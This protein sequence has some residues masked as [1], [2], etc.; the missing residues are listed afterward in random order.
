MNTDTILSS[1]SSRPIETPR[2]FARDQYNRFVSLAESTGNDSLLESIRSDYRKFELG[3]FRLVVMGEIKKGKSS[4][5]NGLLG[6]PS[7]LPTASD[8]ATSTVF[9]IVY[10]ARKSI[11]V[12]FKDDIDTGQKKDPIEIT[13]ETLADY[14]TEAGNPSNGKGVDFIAMQI[15]HPLLK[16]GLVIVDTPGV[17]GLY[18][19]HRD[20]TFRYAPNADAIVFVLDSVESV[21]SRDE[22]LFLKDLMRTA[23]SKVFFV[24][25]KIDAT[26]EETW[27]SWRSRNQSILADEIG[28]P[29]EKQ[30]YFPVSSKTKLIADRRH[31]GKYLEK[32]GYLAVFHYLN[33]ILIPAKDKIIAA[34][35]SRSILRS[36][37]EVKRSLVQ[38]ESVFKQNTAGELKTIQEAIFSKKWDLSKWA[39]TSYRS[40]VQVF[41]ESLN[42][43]KRKSV[44]EMRDALDPQGPLVSEL[45]DRYAKDDSVSAK[46]I[47]DK[48]PE[49]QNQLISEISVKITGLHEKFNARYVKMLAGT[50]ESMALT[51]PESLGGV[52]VSSGIEEIHLVSSEL[53]IHFSKLESVKKPL[54]DGMAGSM[55]ATI[56]V[57]LISAVF[58]PAAVIAG[59]APWLGAIVGGAVGANDQAIRQKTEAINR[60]KSLIGSTC[61]SIQRK[62]IEQLEEII[63]SMERKSKRVFDDGVKQM[64]DTI[65]RE[66]KELETASKNTR[67]QNDAKVSD[68]R[69][70]IKVIEDNI[71]ELTTF[72]R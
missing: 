46:D 41:S 14:G 30:V 6:D 22:V 50:L 52:E 35:L 15:P 71:A 20:I 48:A 16:Q 64:Q 29:L 70:K 5:I 31:S 40:N 3:I 10:G 4:F 63:I 39:E 2:S 62:A 34:D 45:L 38:S 21:M 67:E 43:L 12:F 68:V 18:R 7:F 51:A 66:I 32:S 13:P 59:I 60:L 25:T 33:T 8:I 61:L 9:K 47:V 57:S 36:S 27:R 58:P 55:I 65:N 24:Q 17:G 28:I 49:I 56:G 23:S 69:N 37:L 72:L 53:G 19:A 26:D 1:A 42:D 54:Y 11:K 44:A